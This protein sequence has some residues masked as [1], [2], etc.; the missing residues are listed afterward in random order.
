[1]IR[2]D[3]SAVL[4][5]QVLAVRISHGPDGPRVR[6]TGRLDGVKAAAW[7][8]TEARVPTE[9]PRIF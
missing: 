6:S 4:T 2:H 8:A 9:R 5:D 3:G 1:M 7:A